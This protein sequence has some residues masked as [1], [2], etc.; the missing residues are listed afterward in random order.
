MKSQILH[1][2]L[3][4]IAG[5]AAGEFLD[6]S[7]LEV[8]GLRRVETE[9]SFLLMPYASL[10]MILR[11]TTFFFLRTVRRNSRQREPWML[12]PCFDI[13]CIFSRF[14]WGIRLV[15]CLPT[16]HKV[17]QN[18][19]GADVSATVRSPA[20]TQRIQFLVCGHFDFQSEDTAQ[21]DEFKGCFG[22]SF[23][24]SLN[25]TAWPLYR[26]LCTRKSE[27]A[28]EVKSYLDFHRVTRPWRQ[29]LINGSDVKYVFPRCHPD[30]P[31]ILLLHWSAFTLFR[32]SWVQAKPTEQRDKKDDVG[33]QLPPAQAISSDFLASLY[34]YESV[35]YELESDS[36]ART[37]PGTFVKLILIP[38]S[39]A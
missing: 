25:V 16:S 30:K 32:S 31:A 21:I 10:L 17:L 29:T 1:I 15:F 34:S 8:K 22:S 14:Y 37:S 20:S 33:G 7:L 36:I 11:T 38:M 19:D 39:L 13:F 26:K 28:L 3:C 24:R 4:N 2:V 12:T 27:F 9:S 5:E 6:R 18:A 35:I 23:S